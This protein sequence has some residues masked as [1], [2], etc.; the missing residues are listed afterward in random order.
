M[1][2][3]FVLASSSP[4]VLSSTQPGFCLLHSA[5]VKDAESSGRVSVLT[6]LASD[7]HLTWLVTSS[8]WTH[9]FLAS[10]FFS[11]PWV[12]PYLPNLFPA[13]QLSLYLYL[14]GKHY[15]EQEYSVNKYNRTSDL[16]SD[17]STAYSIH[18]V[19]FW[20]QGIIWIEFYTFKI[21]FSLFEVQLQATTSFYPANPRPQLLLTSIFYLKNLIGSFCSQQEHFKER[22]KMPKINTLCQRLVGK[23]TKI[24][25]TRGYWY[26]RKQ[27][28][29]RKAGM[30]WKKKEKGKHR[31]LKTR[32][33]YHC[34]SSEQGDTTQGLQQ[35]L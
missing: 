1:F 12:S 14:E 22:E 5:L 33:E 13:P 20:T 35:H 24:A 28:E 11:L 26:I 19:I 9:S 2:V 15:T 18:R 21:E 25:E 29:K 30:D 3:L 27:W 17:S 10:S 4:P 7:W 6:S 16:S 32:W 23:E 31:T 8:S 34:P